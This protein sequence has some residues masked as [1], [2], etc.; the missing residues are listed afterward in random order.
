M[1]KTK[2]GTRL[3]TIYIVLVEE[4]NCC[5]VRGATI[6]FEKAQKLFDECK[7]DAD[8][9]HKEFHKVLVDT[10]TVYHVCDEQR[11]YTR[12]YR[13][14]ILSKPFYVREENADFY[15]KGKR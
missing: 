11:P 2:E 10:D 4:S 6:D 15:E 14:E 8:A 7:A 12:F 3:G 1:L 13:A 5:Y 9:D